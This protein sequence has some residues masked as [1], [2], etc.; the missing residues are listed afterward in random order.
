VPDTD[1]RDISPVLDDFD[2]RLG[3]AW[4]KT[5]EERTDCATRHRRPV[6]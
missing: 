1:D 3:R 4:R 5:Q 2:G 6:A